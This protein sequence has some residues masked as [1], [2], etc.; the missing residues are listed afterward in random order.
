M[1]HPTPLPFAFRSPSFRMGRSGGFPSRSRRLGGGGGK[2]ARPRCHRRCRRRR[3][4][5]LR[6]VGRRPLV[7]G[8]PPAP[9]CP[10]AAR[11]CPIS[12]AG[13]ALR[14]HKAAA[15]AAPGVERGSPAP[16]TAA[17]PR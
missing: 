8:P 10:R 1:N 7:P 5:R 14:R 11:R 2:A 6:E 17:Q 15:G 4:R 16:A 12:A 3:K 9:S 13:P